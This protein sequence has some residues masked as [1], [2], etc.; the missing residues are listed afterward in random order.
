MLREGRLPKRWRTAKTI[1]I[2]K[3]G[4]TLSIENLRPISLTSCVGK[5]LEHVLMN[6]WQKY[7][8][9]NDLFPGS[10][11]GFRSKLCTQDAMIQLKAEIIDDKTKMRDNKAILVLDL[12]SAFDKV[13]HSTVLGQISELNMGVRMYNYVREFPSER[14][15]DIHVGDMTLTEK[16]LGSTGT[17]Q[18]S[19]ISSLLFNLVMIGVGRHLKALAD[20]RHTIYADDITPWVPGSSNR[21]IESTLQ[22]AVEAIRANFTI[23]IGLLPEQVRTLGVATEGRKKEDDGRGSCGKGQDRH[24]D[25]QRTGDSGGREDPSAGHV[26]RE[27]S[28]ERRNHQSPFGQG[29]SAFRPRSPRPHAS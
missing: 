22:Q 12:Q 4:K 29:H 3:P 26:N 6:H 19:V 17:P 27:T 24:L 9:D 1:L 8:E 11:I 23:R 14:T 15:A 7:L 25:Q 5:A 18:G 16:K 21:H 2:P 28:H 20:I 10:M 13:K